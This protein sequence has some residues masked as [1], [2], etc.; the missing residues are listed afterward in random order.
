M[1]KFLK[2]TK[3]PTKYESACSYIHKALSSHKVK[4]VV[5]DSE[6]GNL[7]FVCGDLEFIRD[8]EKK[9][10]KILIHES[11][12]TSVSIYGIASRES[13]ALRLEKELLVRGV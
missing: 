3:Y 2:P 13:C 12:G 7:H 10:E 9:I 1:G 11:D 5:E 6:T 8:P 4:V